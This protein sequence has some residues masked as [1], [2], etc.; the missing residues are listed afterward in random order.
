MALV[1]PQIAS[2]L[3][4]VQQ[5]PGGLTFSL[6]HQNSSKQTLPG[7]GLLDQ[8]TIRRTDLRLAAPLQIGGKAAEL[9]LVLQNAGSPVMD[10][11]PAFAFQRRAFVTLQLDN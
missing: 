2:T 9:A 1:A 3:A 4:Y 6:T 11:A 8:T 7:A 10:F 5:L